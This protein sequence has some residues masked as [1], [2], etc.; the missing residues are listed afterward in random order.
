MQPEHG[1]KL[2]LR[3]RKTAG[4]EAWIFTNNANKDRVEEIYVKGWPKAEDLLEG[5]LAIK[6]DRIKLKV[7]SLDVKVL[8]VSR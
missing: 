1:G 4:Q 2:L 8:I 5:P 7:K 6:A 3:K